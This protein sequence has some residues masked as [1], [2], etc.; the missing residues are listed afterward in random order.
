[1][2]ATE[3][4]YY[5]TTTLHLWFAVTSVLLMVVTVWMLIADHFR[6]WKQVQREFQEI[7]VAKL[8][9]AEEEEQQQ[10]QAQHQADLTRVEDE[11]AQAKLTEQ[12]NRGE[13]RVLE[14]QLSRLKGEFD[15][16]DTRKRFKKAELDSLR[17]LYDGMIERAEIDPKERERAR[18][19]LVN[20]IRPA[21][22]ELL[23][24]TRDTE[25]KELELR[26]VEQKIEALRGNI[27]EKLKQKENLERE[28]DRVRRQLDQKEKLY[29]E[30]GFINALLASARGLPI[31]DLAAPPT[32]IDQIS[33]PELTINYNFKDVP[34]Y[35][36]CRTCHQGIDRIGYDTDVDG[37]PMKT[38]FHSHP[39][40]TEG[41]TYLD[42]KG[43]TQ[44]AGLYLDANGPHPIN[45]FGCTIC[46]GGQ[47][48]GTDFTYASH[49][50]NTLEQEHDWVENNHWRSIH[51]WDEPMVP[52]RFIEQSCIKC[53]HQV[54]DVPEAN[55]PKLR[56]GYERIT[57]YGC[58]GCHT[59]GGPGA[60][61]PDL[62]DNRP[63]GPNLA[64]I[65]SKLS[66]E[67]TA[68]WVR[69]PH[70]FKPDT[71][72]PR[73]YDVTNVESPG[74]QPKVAAEVH[75]MTRFLHALSTPPDSFVDPPAN[76]DPEKGKALFLQKGCMACH[77]HRP[78]APEEFPAFV[79]DQV[80]PGVDPA[81][82]YA[83]STLP[84]PAQP[85]ARADFGPNLVNVAAK[86]QSKEQGQRWLTNW[87]HDP[88]SY[89]AQSLMPNLQV[90]LEE[91]A[92]IA[93]WLLSV[94][95]EWQA[96]L[97]L[98]K[99]DSPEV[100]EA[101]DELV[102][103][104]LTKAKSYY[105]PDEVVRGPNA[106]ADLYGG[107]VDNPRMRTVLMSEV[108]ATVDNMSQDE[109]LMYLGQKTINRFGCFGCHNVPGFADAK[110]IG[111]P[112]NGWGTKSPAKLD[113]AHIAEYLTDH[114]TVNDEGEPSYDGT[115]EYY[116]EQIEHQ[117][118]A[119][120]LYQ[121]LHRPRSFDYK[122]TRA[123]LKSWDD[124]LRMPQFAWA[125]DPKAIEE[126]M[127]FVLGLTGEKINAKYLPDLNPAQYA[128]AQGERLL[129]RYNCR[130]CHT[131][132]MPRYT[133]APETD[134]AL[135]LPD[136]LINVEG[137]YGQ[138]ANDYT[139]LTGLPYDPNI[140]SFVLAEKPPENEPI[141][142]A[143]TLVLPREA[144]GPRAPIVIEGMPV[145]T[146]EEEDDRGIVHRRASIQLWKPVTIRGFTFQPYDNITVE[147]DRVAITPPE[148]GDFAWLYAYT[149]SERS[150][151]PFAALWNSLP[152]PLIRQGLKVQT[153]WLT[154]F[155]KDP[156]PIR[157][158]VQLRMPRF[159][160]GQG[161]HPDGSAAGG[162]GNG[163]RPTLPDIEA[164]TRDLANYFAA[165]DGAPF[166][167]QD[168]PQRDRS[169]L[170]A[171]DQAHPHY[172][173]GG[174][175]I[176]TQG[177]CIQCHAI[178][179]FKPTGTDTSA[180]GPDLNQVADR[181]RPDY[182]TEWLAF[183][184]RLLPY[185][186]MPQNIPPRLA[187]GATDPTFVPD[188]FKGKQFD[189][190]EAMRDMLLN[191]VK[192]IEGQLT[193]SPNAPPEPAKPAASG[194]SE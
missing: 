168:I 164:E 49:T 153:P 172:L 119:G 31:V 123:E 21:E 96:P 138:R 152:P 118:R 6:P 122:K 5:G 165:R 130:G 109:K 2:P 185:T 131:L 72:M 98:P 61:G 70:L 10:L 60:I 86:F 40:L 87:I 81:L 50:P 14:S 170:S 11:I 90:S 38:V 150:G 79:R 146:I 37:K 47:G 4:T 121:K 110:P 27:T 132:A 129:S 125:D 192:A 77:Q 8:R 116:L 76:A 188:S 30:G 177:L 51:F 178:G 26:A 103:L 55:A 114:R 135:A 32:K 12:A 159:H 1:M 91:A 20:T 99:V 151:N 63:V 45:S 184:Q 111:T 64:H 42:P 157:P 112:L 24:L 95:A 54:T 9:L 186:K 33:L 41:T 65:A 124:R 161:V 23:V 136:L 120:F 117:T 171:R 62:T 17:S 127:T 7:E 106:L 84:A 93:A 89:H 82:T 180:N 48:S 143:K 156:Y 174:W 105:H 46:H 194:S 67:W 183:P 133:I 182:L 148:G 149:D 160:Y 147:L 191:Y 80:A 44:K 113:Y 142:P 36:R 58:T 173:A 92:D 75:A 78:Y 126:V 66:P 28:V 13:I 107:K 158:A 163:P 145:A 53:H 69:N 139:H 85:H 73:F 169:Y 15:G 104:Y 137:A 108:A 43:K 167:Y 190:V 175:R 102:A 140:T 162:P 155:L 71:R 29:G 187:P 179:Q 3:E 141:D 181:F 100:V 39:F 68:K 94:P 16:L 166:P 52:K 97:D 18:P 56:A 57:K 189:Q 134:L 22:A 154:A 59:I 35:D 34:R 74:D 101:L 115:D 19:Y 176:V 128:L 88:A 25:A 193:A 144:P 83:P